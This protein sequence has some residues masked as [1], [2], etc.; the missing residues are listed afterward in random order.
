MQQI[1]SS[2]CGAIHTTKYFHKSLSFT[3][4]LTFIISLILLSS[5]I[6]AVPTTV[7][8]KRNGGASKDDLRKF[9]NFAAAAYCDTSFFADWNCGPICN[10]TN[11]TVVKKFF[12]TQKTG[13][14][15][16]YNISP[17]HTNSWD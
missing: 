3:F 8:N 10:A 14:R 17:C 9:A 16:I 2:S 15:G 1:T 4:K 7:I 6:E 11:G 13:T 5:L 12:T